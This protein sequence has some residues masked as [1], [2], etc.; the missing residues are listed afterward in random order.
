MAGIP[1]HMVPRGQRSKLHGAVFDGSMKRTLSQLAKETIDIDEVDANGYSPLMAAASMGRAGVMKLLLDKGASVSIVGH[2][3][4]TALHASAQFGYLDATKLLVEA[5]APLEARTSDRATPLHLAAHQGHPEVMRVLIDAGA[6][7]NTR[8]E[9]GE[10]P[11]YS[12]AYEG[13]A[14]AVAELL[15]A[16]ADTR[17]ATTNP[18]GKRLGAFA[19]AAGRGHSRVVSE[20]LRQLGIEACGGSTGGVDALHQAARK[21]RLNLLEMLAEA[22]AV[23]TGGKALAVASEFGREESVKFLLQ[24]KRKTG[25]EARYVR[26]TRDPYGRTPL[27]CTIDVGAKQ[28][29]SP[30]I[31]R[32]LIDAG[33][34]TESTV[35]VVDMLGVVV[36]NDT[37]LGVTTDILRHKVVDGEIA[38]VAQLN[39]LEAI[40]RLLL[41]VEAV[42]AVSWLWAKTPNPP[43]AAEVFRRTDATPATETPLRMMLPLLQ[44]RTRKRGVLLAALSRFDV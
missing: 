2:D 18:V 24:Q 5:G 8:L 29:S 39:K 32:L 27:V 35:R 30:R 42:H 34:D 26:D 41:T 21:Q 36:F 33:A 10:T 7:I 28:L 17:L 22:G 37:P 19:V 16:G 25:S 3:S 44:Q 14:D 11:L 31:A 43:V 15:R 9:A 12:A 40:R 4:A 13:H 1:R 38:T 20:F 23:D 6:C